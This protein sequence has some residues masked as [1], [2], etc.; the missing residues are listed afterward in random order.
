MNYRTWE[1]TT[2]TFP[3]SQRLLAKLHERREQRAPKPL[4]RRSILPEWVLA[5]ADID[6][7]IR[8]MNSTRFGNPDRFKDRVAVEILG[9]ARRVRDPSA[10]AAVCM[11]VQYRQSPRD[12]AAHLGT[13]SLT[14]IGGALTHET[15]GVRT[16]RQ[17]GL[18][19]KKLAI[20]LSA[21]SA[22]CAARRPF[23]D[24]ATLGDEIAT[25]MRKYC[26]GRGR[27]HFS[28]RQ[29]A[30]DLTQAGHYLAAAADG[31][32]T[33]RIPGFMNY[34]EQAEKCE[35]SKL[36]CRMTS[37]AAAAAARAATAYGI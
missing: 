18:S 32:K 33:K 23:S 10:Q 4:L 25:Q 30:A 16:C 7:A 2:I 36:V 9:A 13:I 20:G 28:A 24:W 3:I 8:I 37:P 26:R 1:I 21:A 15:R 17:T 14:A 31:K 5:A 19:D 12:L 6:Q 27:E 22:A 29:A 34:K 35:Y 11:G